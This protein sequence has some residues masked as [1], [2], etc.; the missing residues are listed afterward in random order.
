MRYAFPLLLLTLIG[1]ITG[2]RG[3]GL[4]PEDLPTL[5]PPAEVVSTSIALTENAPPPGYRDALTVERVDR[6]LRELEGWRYEM[7]L[8]FDGVFAQ[9][10]RPTTAFARATVWYNQIGDARRVVVESSGE[11]LQRPE[12]EVFEAVRLGPDAFLVR[13][14]NCLGNAED[15]ARA[16]SAITAGDLVGGARNALPT[17]QKEIING[18]E[19]WRYDF[20]QGDLILPAV[21]FADDTRI[22]SMNSE[23]WVAPEYDAVVRYWVL[24]S[25][26]NARLLSNDLPVTGQLLLQYDLYDIGNVPNITV[27]FGC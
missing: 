23:M 1:L 11:L 26:E 7:L 9:T 19:S 21:R 4:T 3:R 25:I 24:L 17:S 5:V 13:G 6:N 15:D 14:S 10:S 8:E 16:A 18:E 2:C 22:T 12:G 20:G 27:P